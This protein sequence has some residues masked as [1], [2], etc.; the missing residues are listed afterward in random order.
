MS[1]GEPVHSADNVIAAL[2]FEASSP[3]NVT[4]IGALCRDFY[5][6]AKSDAPE[7]VEWL[8][9]IGYRVQND[10]D[11]K[12]Y[13]LALA[14]LW[15]LHNSILFSSIPFRK[16][17]RFVSQYCTSPGGIAAFL[18]FFLEVAKASDCARAIAC[19]DDV[20]SALINMARSVG[21]D[22]TIADQFLRCM[23][24][25]VHATP[26]AKNLYRDAAFQDVVLRLGSIVATSSDNTSS[27][28]LLMYLQTEDI[29]GS[30]FATPATR[31]VLIQIATNAFTSD[32]ELF[33]KI[34]TN[35]VRHT[36]DCARLFATPSFRD[37]MLRL[38]PVIADEKNSDAASLW[39]QAVFD[40]VYC[41]DTYA[42]VP[43]FSVSTV[44]DCFVVLAHVAQGSEGPFRFGLLLTALTKNP[45][46]ANIFATPVMA[47]AC[48][49][50]LSDASSD[51]ARQAM[52]YGLIALM[53]SQSG[54]YYFKTPEMQSL[55]KYQFQ[56]AQSEQVKE[57]MRNVAIAASV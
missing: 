43:V 53:R 16:V 42:G 45:E 22:G 44:H 10:N 12:F 57:C 6:S 15:I 23:C 51:A 9:T 32:V 19:D 2:K 40:L 4:D 30:V 1:A 18:L 56:Q 25:L 50:L 3:T 52:S 5:I 13:F 38:A 46:N 7:I 47:A 39:A 37:A 28:I 49:H 20:R 35:L 21:A 26:E 54:S 14:R 8:L 33:G 55:Y 24:L 41:N 48:R 11:A 27:F 34:V 36:P 29:G 31:D 17:Y